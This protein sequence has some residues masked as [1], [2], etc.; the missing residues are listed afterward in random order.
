MSPLRNSSANSS[1]P[2]RDGDPHGSRSRSRDDSEA[3]AP[4]R[5]VGQPSIQSIVSISIGRRLIPTGSFNHGIARSI[6]W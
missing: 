2:A 4:W 5:T 3:H 6:A 1:R